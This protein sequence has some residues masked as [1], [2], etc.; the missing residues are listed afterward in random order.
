M[1]ISHVLFVL[2][3]AGCGGMMSG[4]DAMRGAVGDAVEE[5]QLHLTTARTIGTM[6]A[7]L[8]EVDRHTSRSDA[9]MD[10]MRSHMSSM[11]HCSGIG[12][13]MDLRDGMR[14]ELDAHAATM[15]AMTDMERAR[16]EVE[17][18]V[19]TMGTMLDDMG[20]MLDDSH[21]SGW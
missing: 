4:P 7:M 20:T 12:T 11:Q 15:H 2:V 1:R 18:H 19:G 14:A 3:A 8:D 10:D 16:A 6:P 5:D 21:C 13:M 17:H 9:I